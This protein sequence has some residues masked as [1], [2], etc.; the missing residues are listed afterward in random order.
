MTRRVL[1]VGGGHNGLVAA[2]YLAS[3]GLSTVV[4]ERRDLVGGG[5]QGDGELGFHCGTVY[6]IT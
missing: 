4:L 5:I 6:A 3:A 1:I 2:Y